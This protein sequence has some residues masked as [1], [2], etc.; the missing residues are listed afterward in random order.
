MKRIFLFISF[1]FIVHLILSQAPGCPDI[2]AGP[3]Q[4]LDCVPCT[5]LSATVLQ[6]GATTTYAV[7]NI[8]YAPPYPFTGG[9]PTFVGVDDVWS[10][11]INLPFDFC[12]YGNLY[13]QI[14]VGANGLITFDITQAGG[15][16]PWSYTASVPSGSL[17]LNSIFGAYHDID[18]SVYGDINYAVLGAYPCR[19]F[20][21]N[22]NNVAQF[23]CNSIATTQQ[24]VLYESTNAIEVYISNKPTCA[25]WNSGNAVVG[26]QNSTGTIGLTPPGYNTGPWTAS[27]IAWRFTPN[28]VPNY[29]VSWYQGA[30]LIGTGLNINVCPS[31]TTTYTAQVVYDCCNGNTVTITD[32][33]LVTVT[34]TLIANAGADQT[35]CPGTTVTLGGSPTGSNGAPPITYSWSPT[36]GLSN[37]N[38]ANPTVTPGST[39]TYTVTVTDN[40]GCVVADN[41]TITV[42][43]PSVASSSSTP[44]N[45]G[46]ADG[47]ISITATGGGGTPYTY[48][49]PASSNQTGSFTGLTAGTYTVTITDAIGCTTTQVMTVTGSGAVNS[50]F[51]ASADQCLTGNT[52]SFTNTGDTG[53]GITWTW[54]FPSGT[55]ANSTLEN[56]S[57]VTW[58]APGQYTITQTAIIGACTDVTTYNINVWPMPTANMSFTNVTCNGYCNGTATAAGAS[59]TAPYTYSWSNGQTGGTITN[60][61]P[62]LY[63]VTITDSHGCT[64]TG[65]VTITQP[66]AITFTPSAVN[67]TCG[68]PNGSVGATGVS[69]GTVTTGYSYNWENGSSTQVGT[70]ATVNNLPAGTYYVTITDNNGCTVTGSASITDQ[71]GGTVTVDLITPVSC[72][73]M[74]DGAISITMT[75][76]TLPYTYSWTG[77]AGFTSSNEDLTNIGAGTY[78]VTVTDGSGCQSTTS[79]TVTELPSVT[80]S[81]I[82]TSNYNGEDISCFGAS[83]GSVDLSASGG[84]GTYTYSWSGPGGYTSTFQDISGLQA[85]TY[86][87]TIT[88]GNGCSTTQTITLTQ[89]TAVA[90]SAIVSSNYNGVQISCNGASDGSVNMTPSGGT[91]S[92]TYNWT[93]PGGFSSALEDISGLQAGTYNVTVTDVNGCTATTNISLTA[94]APVT[95]TTSSTPSACG[96]SDGSVTAS[97]VAGGT[98]TYSFVW[99]NSVPA[100]VGNTSTVNNLPSGNYTVIVSDANGC[101]G[102][103]SIGISDIGAGT[104]TVDL[105]VDVSCYGGYDGSIDITMS[106]GTTPYTY[107]WSGPGGY[108]SINED[109]TNLGAGTYLLTVTDGV[110]CHN[111]TTAI[112]D[113]PPVLTAY[114]NITSYYNGEDISCYGASDGT[115]DLVAGGGT[116]AYTY[117]WTGPGGYTSVS[118]DPANVPAGTFYVTVTDGNGCTVTTN[119]TLTQP[120]AVNIP[121][122]IVSDYYG[123]GVSCFGENDGYIDIT[124]TGGTGAYIYTWNGPGGFGSGSQDITNL[125][126]GTY[127]VIVT[128][129][130]NCTAISG[131]TLTEP[132]EIMVS[133][134]PQDASCYNICDGTI[135]VSAA[136]GSGTYTYDWSNGMSGANISNLCGGTYS[137]TVTDN[138]GCY[139]SGSTIISEPPPIVVIPPADAH[140]CG[141]QTAMLTASASGGTGNLTYYWDGVPGSATL[142]TSPL[143]QSTYQL[144]VMDANNCMSDIYSV[145]V[146]V[147]PAVILDL[148]AN[149]TSVCP[150]EPAVISASIH[151]GI[152]PY[153]VTDMYGNVTSPPFVITPEEDTTVTITVTDQCGSQATDFIEISIYPLPPVDFSADNDAGC[154]PFTVNFIENS[155]D[156]GQSYVWNFGDNDLDN[157]SFSKNPQHTYDESGVYD[158]TLTVTSEEGCVS[159]YTIYQMISVY[160]GPEARFMADPEVVSIIKPMVF[161]TNQ[162]T[163][164]DGYT[165][166]FGDGDTSCSINPFHTYPIY[167]T[168]TYN[169]ALVA[170]TNKG[171]ADTTYK[172]I[173]VKNEYTFYAPTAFS[174]DFD[175]INDYFLVKANGIDPRNFKLVI[176]DRWGE[177]VFE[178]DNLFEGWD[179]RIKGRE[180]GK[181]GTYTWLCTYKDQS[182]TEHQQ[183]GAVTIIR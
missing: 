33:V 97:N 107:S 37:P 38:A 121:S 7:S 11:V 151:N 173:V 84:S 89:P 148:F 139:S 3:D 35:V 142:A 106:N 69:G 23:S 105:V 71:G 91:G 78:N 85:G 82:I 32:N 175:G 46:Q 130:N 2:D 64:G 21:V 1:L 60:L 156:L 102:T 68:Q 165:W 166:I 101:T 50:G 103:G 87:V 158:V 123:L 44:E 72:S 178:T 154:V 56:P 162:S 49:I 149:E 137:V 42:A 131:G 15:Y 136:G 81:V 100:V 170:W 48:A 108:S 135:S 92:Y 51:T 152:P 119:I 125:Y 169:V 76:G 168:G 41:I 128:D 159:N 24:I 65:S 176:Y 153:F 157:L 163:L 40:G 63:T 29:T 138:N 61:C 53:G 96:Q 98:G 74:T 45:C 172:E 134:T 25:G 110:G 75:G 127:N 95:L 80:A 67:S 180:I 181:N 14:V 55:P 147:T 113:Q 17:P 177:S 140:I 34:S 132:T 115:I 150:G 117:S 16:C 104:L 20:V 179:G 9:T 124:V 52:F 94:P 36:A 10:G 57:G 88:D 73:G 112:V 171:C 26:I 19:T 8:P 145:T 174:P 6:T 27:N 62:G 182:G 18:P 5:N 144:Y 90:S 109:I 161:F 164:A 77:P 116:P 93:G 141:G 133:L 4:L 99:T 58:S 39:T 183:A 22:Y 122:T 129:A 79:A 13:N 47:T 143:S 28:G 31:A 59:G 114:A 111:N 70:T 146:S 30:T 43:Q 66:T 167:P 86:N 126:A 155:P 118:E 83:N 54:S 12:F 120:A 160:P